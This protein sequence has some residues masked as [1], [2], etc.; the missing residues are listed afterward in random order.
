MEKML[1]LITMA[2]DIKEIIYPVPKNRIP[3]INSRR[4]PEW[5]TI[6]EMAAI[7]VATG[8]GCKVDIKPMRRQPHADTTSSIMSI[9]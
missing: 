2:M 7:F 8:Q 1:I 4:F 6:I 5:L 9:I 3:K